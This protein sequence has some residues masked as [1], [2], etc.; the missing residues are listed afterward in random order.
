MST[1]LESLLAQEAELQFSKL[2]A[3]TVWRLGSW[4]VEKARKEGLRIAVGITKG[5]QRV[6][7]WAADGTTPDNDFWIDRKTKS[8]Y[9]WGH[10]SFYIGR[11]LAQENT[12]LEAKYAASEAEYCAHGGSFPLIVKGAGVVGTLTV[13]GL[14]QEDDHALA[15]EAIRHVLRK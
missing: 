14:K 5:G 11:K 13:S 10:S 15:V 1:S 2:D 6:F 8:V 3:A 4:L 9:R 7:H 12:T